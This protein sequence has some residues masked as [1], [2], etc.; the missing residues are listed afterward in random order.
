MYPIDLLLLVVRNYGLVRFH[1][2]KR[3]VILACFGKDDN[4][5]FNAIALSWCWDWM[6]KVVFSHVELKKDESMIVVKKIFLKIFRWIYLL[7][8]NQNNLPATTNFIFKTKQKHSSSWS[9]TGDDR[10]WPVMQTFLQT[11][12]ADDLCFQ[13]M[14][15]YNNWS[16]QMDFV[17]FIPLLPLF[18]IAF[19]LSSLLRVS[20]S[21]R[22]DFSIKP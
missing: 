12:L 14:L 1:S 19:Q 3:N 22:Y 13:S 5:K 6:G 15:I 11:S 2:Q 4:T 18:F 8:K 17:A 7:V 21:T 16:F 20:T 9:F 10:A